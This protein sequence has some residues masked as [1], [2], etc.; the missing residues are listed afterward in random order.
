MGKDDLKTTICRGRVHSIDEVK[1]TEK[2][3]EDEGVLSKTESTK[4][5]TLD[6]QETAEV[7]DFILMSG[8]DAF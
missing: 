6:Y 4:R 8:Y 2:E 7:D 1:D 5:I 3:D